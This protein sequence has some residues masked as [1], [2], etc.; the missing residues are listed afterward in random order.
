MACGAIQKPVQ[1]SSAGED[2]PETELPMKTQ[3]MILDYV[4]K[5]VGSIEER[6]EEPAL[7]LGRIYGYGYELTLE[8]ENQLRLDISRHPKQLR[9]EECIREQKVIELV[10]LKGQLA[11]R[12]YKNNLKEVDQLEHELFHVTGELVQKLYQKRS[13]PQ[14]LSTPALNPPPQELDGK[15]HGW[16]MRKRDGQVERD[17]VVFVPRDKLLPELL[18]H[19]R[20][21]CEA[22]G[23]N[24]LH[25]EAI[26]QLRVRVMKWQ[27]DHPK[28][29][30]IPDTSPGEVL[31]SG[32]NTPSV[33]V[34]SAIS[35]LV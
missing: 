14:T 8:E 28:E 24:A 23:A 17:F 21:L 29:V 12:D 5:V 30:K 10:S 22:A 9:L 27:Q 6:S 20:L 3:K 11:D 4:E 1:L 35:D 34:Q 32:P 16:V 18:R 15:F 25:L 13:T 7:V 31:L 26:D 33:F 19:Y 2:L